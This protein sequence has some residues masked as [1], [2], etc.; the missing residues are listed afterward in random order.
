M[1]SRTPQFAAL[2]VVVLIGLL[3][4]AKVVREAVIAE[5]ARREANRAARAKA[6]A[7]LTTKA[8]DKVTEKKIEYTADIQACIDKGG[9]PIKTLFTGRL[10]RCD[11]PGKK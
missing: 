7:E 8:I 3:L 1:N 10:K 2:A 5:E 6:I 11:F 4:A 9:V